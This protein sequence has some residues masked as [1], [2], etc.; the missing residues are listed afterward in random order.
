MNYMSIR[1]VGCLFVIIKFNN[2]I[3]NK[4]ERIK[5]EWTSLNNSQNSSDTTTYMLCFLINSIYFPKKK[6]E[7]FPFCIPR[8]FNRSP[9]TTIITTKKKK[10]IVYNFGVFNKKTKKYN[11]KKRSGISFK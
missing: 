3:I 10:K 5:K 2:S 9:P 8:I 1:L 11:F 7:R 6:N 4:I